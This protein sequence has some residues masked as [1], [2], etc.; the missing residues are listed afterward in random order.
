MAAGDL[1]SPPDFESLEAWAGAGRVIRAGASDLAG[2]RL[3]GKQKAALTSCGVPLL[4]SVVDTTL[5]AAEPQDGRYRLAGTR[6]GLY[7]SGCTYLAEPETGL[8]SELES[9]SGRFRFVNSSI[10][11]WLCSLH[12]V[13]T[14][15]ASSTAIQ[16]W[17]EDEAIEDVALAELADLLQRIT[18]LD[19]PAYGD[20]GNHETHFWPA[21]LDR[22]LY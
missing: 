7:Q 16:T 10:N 4:E 2:W 19:P 1:P 15:L 11:H 8:V 22:W 18:H 21:V 12:L 9:S 14:W 5:F 3:P 20:V 17:D 6:V 13:G